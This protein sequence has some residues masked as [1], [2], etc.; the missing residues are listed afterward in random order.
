MS[1]QG[2]FVAKMVTFWQISIQKVLKRYHFGRKKSI[3][4]VTKCTVLANFIRILS[5]HCF[6][7]D[8]YCI[9]KPA[10]LTKPSPKG[11]LY[12]SASPVA[13]RLLPLVPIE[14]KQSTVLG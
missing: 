11:F 9:F 5:K 14:V 7:A 10:Y 2:F 1:F 6:S 8:I 12:K 13:F 4:S 3:L